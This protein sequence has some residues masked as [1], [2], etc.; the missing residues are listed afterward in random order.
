MRILDGQPGPEIVKLADDEDVEVI[1]MATHGR[2]GVRRAVLG[3]VS[4]YVVRNAGATVLLVRPAAAVEQPEAKR[5]AV[6]SAT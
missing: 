2:S 4:D 3:S 5:E 1:V 6:V